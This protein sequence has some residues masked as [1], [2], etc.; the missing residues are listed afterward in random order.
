MHPIFDREQLAKHQADQHGRDYSQSDDGY[1]D[2]AVAEREGWTTLAG[3]GADGWD[4]GDWP[5]VV[6]STRTRTATYEV[7]GLVRPGQVYEIAPEL[8]AGKVA[9][10]READRDFYEHTDGG[11]EMRQTCEGDTT[12]Y[13]FTSEAERAAAIDYLFL[14]YIAGS[15]DLSGDFPQLDREQLDAGTLDVPERFRGPYNAKARAR[16]IA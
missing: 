5:Y 13:R 3:W 2:M 8:L 9:E 1:G 6:I 11:Y 10:L 12:V 15:G 7:F 14:W 4:L 16:V